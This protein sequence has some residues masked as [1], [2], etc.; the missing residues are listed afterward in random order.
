LALDFPHKKFVISQRQVQG[1][2][3]PHYMKTSSPVCPA[4]SVSKKSSGF[5]L[6]ELLVVIAI[7]AILAGMLLPALAKAKD[8]AIKSQCGSNLRQWGIALTLYATDNQDFFPDNSAG[9]DFSW[10]SPAMNNIFYPSYLYPN[11]PGSKAKKKERAR[12]DVIYCPTDQWHRLVEGDTASSTNLIGYVYLPGRTAHVSEGWFTSND[13]LAKWLSRKK[14]GTE[15][16]NAP[17]MTDKIQAVGSN[18][19]GRLT[20]FDNRIPYANHR[21]KE[22]IST[23][24]NFL[25]EDGH[26]TWRKFDQANYK[27][28]ID[29]GSRANNWVVFFKP[30]DLDTGPW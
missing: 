27:S 4:V 1:V 3:D 28:T 10:M 14:F 16:R 29:V 15:Y 20:W 26:V 30:G 23:G 17:I 6:I 8:T 18:P 11:R 19:A 13:P 25:Y 21:G 7:I 24:G 2:P 5:T 9:Q 22:S 12:A